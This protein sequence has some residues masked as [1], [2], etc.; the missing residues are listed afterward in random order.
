M[1]YHKF[2]QIENRLINIDSILSIK[3][4]PYKNYDECILYLEYNR[5]A[6]SVSEPHFDQFHFKETK[7][8]NKIFSLISKA[9]LIKSPIY[10]DKND[11]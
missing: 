9:L 6:R 1:D 8:C 10:F 5:N 11:R 3:L 2:I 4:H 7:E